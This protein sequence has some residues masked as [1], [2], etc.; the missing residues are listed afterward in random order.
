MRRVSDDTLLWGMALLG[1]LLVSLA[2]FGAGCAGTNP[3]RA[4]L[5]A[6]MVTLDGTVAGLEIYDREHQEALVAQADSK[7]WLL[8]ALSKYRARRQ[9][10][11]DT[12]VVIYKAIAVAALNLEDTNVRDVIKLMKELERAIEKFKNYKEPVPKDDDDDS[13]DSDKTV[14]VEVTC[15]RQSAGMLSS[16]SLLGQRSRTSSPSFAADQYH[17]TR[18]SRP[19]SQPWV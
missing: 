2:I 3:K 4:A 6:A 9:V 10:I 14:L 18:L 7:E 13:K 8:M 16:F 19:A 15:R 12:I 5:N 11:L 1:A 17:T